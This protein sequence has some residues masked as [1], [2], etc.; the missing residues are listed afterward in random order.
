[1]KPETSKNLTI[2][3]VFQPSFADLQITL[4]YYHI[5]I[6]NEIS[7]LGAPNILNL[8]YDSAQFRSGSPYCT[9]IS[10]RDANNNIASIDDRFLN[11]AE[12][13]T[14]GLDL[15]VLYRKEFNF[16]RVSLHGEATYQLHHTQTLFP[17]SDPIDFLGTF[18]YPQMVFNTDARL[19]HGD[20]EFIYSTT[21][22][23][24][25]QQ[26]TLTGETP[27]GRYNLDQSAQL[28]HTLS[29]AYNG[30]K[31]RAEIGVRNITNSYSPV[32]SNNPDSAYA[33][34]I[35]EFANGNGNLEL[36]GRTYFFNVYKKF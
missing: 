36:F 13:T 4:D 28:F 35:G 16:G 10:P 5:T 21:F 33:S 24:H 8:C 7:E 18:G 17:G 34:R 9:L 27:G 14:S 30:D 32:I 25:Q 1:M 6:N 29:V 23:G 11:I 31:W 2:G 26:Y 3:G 19:R 12:E 22:L 20:W 15:E